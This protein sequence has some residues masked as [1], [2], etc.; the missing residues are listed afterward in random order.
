MAES[1]MLSWSSG[2]KQRPLK[3]PPCVRLVLAYISGKMR[4]RFIRLT[5]ND[6]VKMEMSPYGTAKARIAYRLWHGDEILFWSAPTGES[7][8][9]SH[10]QKPAGSLSFNLET[11]W[12]REDDRGKALANGDNEDTKVH[13]CALR[14]RSYLDKEGC[15]SRPPDFNRPISFL[16]FSPCWPLLSEWC[17]W[18]FLLAASLKWRSAK[19][20]RDIAGFC[21]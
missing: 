10:Y 16:K 9:W 20:G 7:E 21:H 12:Y 4:K 19:E 5:I 6:R 1:K 2:C 14:Q 18:D 11:H 17:Q 15:R 8:H 3:F 13:L